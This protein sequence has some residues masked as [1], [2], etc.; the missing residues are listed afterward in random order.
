MNGNGPGLG[1]AAGNIF[2]KLLKV[3]F[4]LVM[5]GFVVAVGLGIYFFI[6]LGQKPSTKDDAVPFNIAK[7]E[8][9][10]QITDDL[11]SKQLIR[12]TFVFRVRAK[13]LGAEGKVQAGQVTLRHD[14]TV[15]QVLEA[16]TSVRLNDRTVTIIEGL[17]L[18][19]IAQILAEKGWD[20]NK[21]IKAVREE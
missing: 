9:F 1:A 6:E 20:A 13:M 21:F 3:F 14:M 2:G 4:G 17:R 12:N 15:D 11:Y 10:S 19:Q 16:I 8:T 7:G 5:V 18:E